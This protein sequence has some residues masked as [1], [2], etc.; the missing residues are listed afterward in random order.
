MRQQICTERHLEKVSSC[1]SEA[2]VA[3]ADF[4]PSADI[5]MTVALSDLSLGFVKD[6]QFPQD[7]HVLLIQPATDHTPVGSRQHQHLLP[8]I[9]ITTTAPRC[10]APQQSC[11]LHIIHNECCG[12]YAGH[13]VSAYT[14]LLLEIGM[15]S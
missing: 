1:T 11:H 10:L 4:N 12:S 9:L 13:E 2:T 5:Q 14:I 7:G 15:R 3:F 8:H 6:R